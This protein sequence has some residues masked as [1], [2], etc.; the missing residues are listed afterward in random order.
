MKTKISI[1]L[2]IIAGELFNSCEILLSCLDGNGVSSTEERSVS[3]FT[4]INSTGDF[5]VNVVY[6]ED[7]KIEVEADENLQQYIKVSVEDGNLIL[8]TEEGRCLQ[9]QNGIIIT[10]YCPYIESITLTSSGDVELTGFAADYFNVNL[11]G[12][13]DIDIYQL[14]VTKSLELNLSGSGDIT[15]DGKSG[16]AKYFLS[17]S[18]DIRAESMRVNNCDLVLSGSGDIHTFTYNLLQIH[19]SGSGNVY[20]YGNPASK[21]ERVTGSGKVIKK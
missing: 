6:A 20:Y 10:V 17:G 3:T 16:E 12:S 19:L 15:I 8:E 5:K 9:S 18:G 4:G 2:I 11:T 13:G 14:T 1:L 21:E 7:T